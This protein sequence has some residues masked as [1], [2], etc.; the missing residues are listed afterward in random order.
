MSGP[1]DISA[2]LT[3]ALGA[4]TAA[5]AAAKQFSQEVKPP[6]PET[7]AATPGPSTGE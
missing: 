4:Y 2:T 3:D 6:E 5:Q 7:P 1:L